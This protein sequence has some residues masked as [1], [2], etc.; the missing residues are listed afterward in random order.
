MKRKKAVAFLAV[1]GMAAMLLGCGSTLETGET[2]IVPKEET[3]AGTKGPKAD[4]KEAGSTVQEAEKTGGKTGKAQGV[5]TGRIAD[6]VNAPQTY[7]DSFSGRTVHV[8]ADA[9]VIVPDAEGF[10]K[11]KVKPRP[12]V[13]EDYDAVI[14]VLLG[15][16]KIWE[17]D[18]EAMGGFGATKEELQ[19]K[20]H[21][22]KAE[23]AAGAK[24][25][26]LYGDKDITYGETLAQLE[27]WIKDA[28][29]EVVT[30][31]KDATVRYEPGNDEKNVISGYVTA[32]GIDYIVYLDNA[33]RD[34]WY[35]NRFMVEKPAEGGNYVPG[36]DAD[37][38]DASFSTE[39][40]RRQAEALVAQLGLTEYGYAGEE[41]YISHGGGDFDGA[42]KKANTGYCIHFTRQIDNIPVTY[43]KGEG[44]YGQ[45]G[46]ITWPAE[47]LDLIY[48]GN[49]FV[50]LDWDSPYTVE[51]V[52]DEYV[53]L[54]P[55]SDIQDVFQKMM[56]EKYGDAKK[57]EYHIDRVQ[58][59]YA[60]V[61]KNGAETEGMMIPVWDF[62]GTEKI[63]IGGEGGTEAN[64]IEN[65]GAYESLLTVNA[66]D[67]T[68]VDKKLG[69]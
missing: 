28:P 8:T 1:S 9:A 18:V 25:S 17:R 6:Q 43:A 24:E 35:W 27:K 7:Q 4:A 50:C 54:L 60:R 41:Y 32:D 69:Y 31:E 21:G 3:S 67:G 62:F 16:G 64:V 26:D 57:A 61:R 30:V 59:G 56:V 11:K 12:F 34:D 38:K 46:D 23:M 15:G 63:Y 68:I 42:L 29:E 33:M 44:L 48:D 66:M 2:V 14:R 5:M 45:G 20:M 22:I 52:S 47:Y 51:D 10:R 55:F 53:F 36:T 19:I 49:G 37:A 65:K 39:E 13:Q 40:I 58:L